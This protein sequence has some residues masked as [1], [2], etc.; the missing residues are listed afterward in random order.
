MSLTTSIQALAE[1]IAEEFKKKVSTDA[2][3]T[4]VWNAGD[5][6]TRPGV[7]VVTGQMYYDT[8]LGKPLWWDGSVWKD[9]A[10]STAP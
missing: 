7:G 9:S 3:Q 6:A 4:S 10:G 1:R 5:S 2:L 8:T